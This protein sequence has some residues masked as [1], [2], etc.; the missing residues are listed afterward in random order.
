MVMMV[1]M[2]LALTPPVDAGI[3]TEC[4]GYNQSSMVS[5]QPLE[6]NKIA[7]SGKNNLIISRRREE[8]VGW[9]C[10]LTMMI[11]RRTRS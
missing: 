3:R 5:Q 7:S 8:S 9:S 11:R 1:V 2:V 4:P 6:M 10:R